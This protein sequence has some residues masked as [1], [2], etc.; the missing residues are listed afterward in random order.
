MLRLNLQ[1]DSVLRLVKWH[2][3]SMCSDRTFFIRIYKS[4]LQ[5][6]EHNNFKF[7]YSLRTLSAAEIRQGCALPR[8]CEV[9][10][11][12]LG[13]LVGETARYV[14][15]RAALRGGFAISVYIF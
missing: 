9:A 15:G 3:D 14:A 2:Q 1:T 6:Y 12:Q 7:K 13:R 5:E 4:S 10:S 11:A 8:S